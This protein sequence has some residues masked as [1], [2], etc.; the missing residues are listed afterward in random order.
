MNKGKKIK[1]LIFSIMLCLMSS[2]LFAVEEYVSAIYK[3][4]DRIFAAKSDIQL[5]SILQANQQDRY[6]YLIENYTMKKIRRLIISND[7]D[8]ALLAVI[9]VIENN[10]ENEEAVEM[11]SV[12][13]D[14]YKVQQEYELEQE[15]KR[16]Q[17][18]VRIEK[19]KEKQRPAVEK[20]YVTAHKKEGGSVY[21][22]EKETKMTSYWWRFAFGMADVSWLINTQ[23]NMNAFNYGVGVDFNYEYTLN[24]VI[25]GIDAAANFKFLALGSNENSIP[26]MVNLDIG[27][28]LGFKNLSKN[29]FIKVGFTGLLSSGAPAASSVIK[30]FYTPTIGLC[31]ERIKLG[32]VGLDLGADYYIGHL[33]TPGI[34]FGMGAKINCTIPFAE[35]EKLRLNFNIGLQDKFFIKNGGIENRASLVL[36][37]GAE[38]VS[39]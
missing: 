30:E 3:Q 20:V 39:K 12:I 32:K 13:S 17:E 31:Y 18:V 33:Y 38:N 24:S 1:T 29:F 21:V 34:D 22:A 14:A 2:S 26:L 28:K 9:V 35:M 5:N 6:Y 37:I 8:Y 7:Y 16:Q 27:P 36:A 4:I 23:E 19:E 25:M 10:L 15:E 11:Y